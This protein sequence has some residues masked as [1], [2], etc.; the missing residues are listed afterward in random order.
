MAAR[1]RS[2]GVAGARGF[3]LNVSNFYSTSTEQAYGDRLAAA[4]GGSHFVIDTSRNGNGSDGQWCNP[5]GR[6]LGAAWTASTGDSANDALLWVKTPGSSD[7][8]CQGGPP[9]GTFW[10]DYALGLAARAS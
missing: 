8:T 4:L 10:T 6:A 3:S 5:A 7:G 1:L 2:A 9:A